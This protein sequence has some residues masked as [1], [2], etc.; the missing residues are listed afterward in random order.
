MMDDNHA[1]LDWPWLI[2]WFAMAV[3]HIWFWVTAAKW[4]LYLVAS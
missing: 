2:W 3:I 1:G 4:F